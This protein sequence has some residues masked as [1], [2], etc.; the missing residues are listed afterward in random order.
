MVM[1]GAG[2]LLIMA[3]LV[4]GFRH[5][6]GAEVSLK[7]LLNE[8]KRRLRRKES[9]H[10][11][12]AATDPASEGLSKAAL[13][14]LRREL[15]RQGTEAFLVV[16]GNRVVY[17]WYPGWSGPNARQL[18]TAMAKAVTG[19]VA[20]LAAASDGRIT[21]DDPA[22]KYIP[23][24]RGDSIRSKIRI[25]DL[26]SHE[27]GMD[28]VDFFNPG[29]GWKLTYRD[30]PDQRFTMALH[31][32]PILFTPGTRVS[33]SGVGYYALAYA[34]AADFNDAPQHDVQTFLR[35]RIMLPLGIPDSDWRL[36]YDQAYQVDGMTLYAIGSGAYYTARAVARVGQLMLDRGRWGDRW[37]LDSTLVARS[38]QPPTAILPPDSAGQRR[39]PP[40]AA[41]G[42]VLNTRG[43]WPEV[44]RDAFAGI[45]AGH[46]IVLVVPS[47]DLVM[48]RMGKQLA[49]DSDFYTALQNRLLN[50]LMKSIVGPSSRMQQSGH[51]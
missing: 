45:G 1:L 31:T 25:R 44:P 10:V 26:A 8:A 38:V 37:L 49:P 28:D 27:S 40:G 7:T 46:E 20:L 32:A 16:R 4:A 42:W 33:Y 15:A 5:P 3:A 30:H 12:W 39:A 18:T 48:V 43:S 11:A 17:E 41:S 24:W 34:L 13:D 50:P 19:S 22:W 51:N 35:E 6:T 36:S 23:A 14:S 21:L 2:T 9:A 47:L 29:S